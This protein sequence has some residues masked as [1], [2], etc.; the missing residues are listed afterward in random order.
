MN[1]GRAAVAT[2]CPPR[3]EPDLRPVEGEL[4]DDELAALAKAL[5]HPARI[6]ILRLLARRD[7]CVC[8]D[9][10]DELP[11]AQSTV[12]QHLKVLK[13]A[14]SS[15]ARSTGHGS[16]I[17]SSPARCAGSRPWSVGCDYPADDHRFQ[18][19]EE[20]VHANPDSRL[21]SRPVLLDRR[22]WAGSRP[23]AGAVRGRP[24]VADR[25]GRHRRAL[26]PGPTAGAPSPRLRPS[27]TPWPRGPEVLPLIVVNDRVAVEGAYPS[28][29]TLA[30]LAGVVVRKLPVAAA[31]ACCAPSPAEPDKPSCC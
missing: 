1:E 8:G 26:Q 14:A 17:A 16:A 23:R 10:V 13:D 27:R 31:S 11:L 21:R 9:I 22:V 2:C 5:A 20:P 6:K 24:G 12:S 7:A 28:R 18:T 3:S 25:P 29:E 4:A 19:I 15:T 30:A